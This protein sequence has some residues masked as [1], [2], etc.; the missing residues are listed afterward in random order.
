[1]RIVIS[2]M[3]AL[4]LC[5]SVAAETATDDSVT[6]LQNISQRLHRSEIV[7][8]EF[9]QQRHLK[10]LSRPLTSTGDFYHQQNLGARWRVLEPY[11]STIHITAQGTVFSSEQSQPMAEDF[12][13]LLLALLL[14]DSAQLS[15]HFQVKAVISESHWDLALTPRSGPW[16]QAVTKIL[17]TGDSAVRSIDIHEHGGDRT[18]VAI[19][20]V[21]CEPLLNPAQKNEFLR[22]VN[23][24]AQ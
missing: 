18:V 13:Q 1:M 3:L 12:G 14:I 11:P 7:R 9:V 21:A 22:A 5:C 23:Q 6:A 4:L 15:S 24:P 16:Q 10:I 20:N 17:V 19:E 2:G 8:G